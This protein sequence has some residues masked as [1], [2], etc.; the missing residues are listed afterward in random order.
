MMQTRSLT[1]SH[2]VTL[3]ALLAGMSALATPSA[4]SG[5]TPLYQDVL[6]ARVDADGMVDYK[7]LKAG[8]QPLDDYVKWL[9]ELD[10]KT[11]DD[12]SVNAKIALWLNAYNALTLTA[13]IDHYPIRDTFWGNLRGFPKNSIRQIADVWD[14]KRYTV[15]GRK[16]SLG[17]IEH[18]V[19]R[20]EF[21]EPRIHMALVCAAMSCPP[22]RNEP[23][24]GDRL[25]EQLDDQA[26]RFLAHERKFRIDRGRG[27]V[28]LSP[29]FKWFGEDF[30]ETYGTSEGFAGHDATTRAALN[31]ISRFVSPEDAKYLR[32]G[33]YSTVWFDYDWSLNERKSK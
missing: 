15:M 4:D 1:V 5:R 28:H 24:T 20:A 2:W 16:M 10:R 21:N 26:R 8:R 18:E 6:T 30:V 25:V 27:K 31:F 19:L 23:Y 14:D 3:A 17:G 7:Q 12:W 33:R 29:I 22:L 13:I 9:A 11:Y 32:E